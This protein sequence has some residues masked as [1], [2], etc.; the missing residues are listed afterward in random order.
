[1]ITRYSEF[2]KPKKTVSLMEKEEYFQHIDGIQAHID[3]MV[4]EGKSKEEIN[5]GLGEIFSFLGGGFKQTL[6]QYA[7]QWMLKKLG[8][9]ADGWIME[10]AIQIVTKIKF[11]EIGNYFGDGSC[12][13]WAQAI[14]EGLVYFMTQKAGDLILG[15]LKIAPG[16]ADQRGGI[17]NTL[18]KTITNGAGQ[19]LNN[20]E[21]ITNLE[22]TIEGKICG[23]GAPGFSDIFKGKTA[24]PGTQEELKNQLHQASK[25]DPNIM[26]QA[27]GIGLL[28]FLG[29][30]GS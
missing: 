30:G 14:Q 21:F 19:A 17:A 20:T 1:M 9:P 28:S 24:D 12:K 25:E 29:F 5:E 11:T 23:K 8:L 7:A 4:L 27:K 10:L 26:G 16:N 15:S 2:S 6:Y 18:I 22:Q 3:V 13:Y